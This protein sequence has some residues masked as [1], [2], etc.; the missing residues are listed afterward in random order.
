MEGELRRVRTRRLYGVLPPDGMHPA[1][2]HPARRAGM[3]V[4]L[5]RVRARQRYQTVSRLEAHL[6]RERT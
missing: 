4:R 2:V 1:L 6:Q 3:E 5:Q